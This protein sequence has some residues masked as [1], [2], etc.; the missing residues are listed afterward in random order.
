MYS[1]Y[2]MVAS[3]SALVLMI[4]YTVAPLITNVVQI[5]CKV[6]TTGLIR[7]SHLLLDDPFSTLL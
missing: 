1:S 3:Y 2:C 4:G 7:D 5:G 6:L